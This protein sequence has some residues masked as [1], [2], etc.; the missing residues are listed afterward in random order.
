MNDFYIPLKQFRVDLDKLQKEIDYYVKPDKSK[1][2]GITTTEKMVENYDFRFYSG[3]SSKDKN[4]IR[5]LETGEF[6]WDVVHWPKVLENSYIKELSDKFS[7][8]IQVN[9]PR[10]RMSHIF[11]YNKCNEIPYHHDEH[12]PYRIHIALKTNPKAIWRFRENGVVTEIHQ[13][14]DGVP[15]LIKTDTIEHSVSI[16]IGT[17]RTHLWYQY[18]HQIS[19]DILKKL[20]NV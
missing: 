10:C 3:V 13:P 2:Y 19:N 5:R 15:V 7:E 20:K 16:P 17:W 9:K 8:L 6:D 1:D 18:H 12:T 11:G 4:G 14:T